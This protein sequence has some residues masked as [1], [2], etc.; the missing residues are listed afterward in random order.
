MS[1]IHLTVCD[2]CGNPEH[3]IPHE[4]YVVQGGPEL[5]ICS[6][7]QSKPFRR[8]PPHPKMVALKELL[9]E[10]W[11]GGVEPPSAG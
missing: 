4:R 10:V 2:H 9:S 3:G 11:R 6:T 8:I 5:H 7:C 1:S